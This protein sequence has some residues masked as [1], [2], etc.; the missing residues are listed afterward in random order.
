MPTKGFFSQGVVVF[1]SKPLEIAEIGDLLGGPAKVKTISEGMSA[2]SGPALIV[3]FDPEKGG[4]AVVDLTNGLWPDAMGDPKEDPK[5][6]AAWSMGQFG[7][8]AYPGGLSRATDYAWNWERASDHL[9]LQQSYVRIRI[10]YVFGADEDTPVLPKDYDPR[11]ELDYLTGLVQGLL[12]HP[13]AI[14]YFNPNGEVLMTAEQLD[15]SLQ[16]HSENELPP[17]ETWSNIRLYNVDETWTL[18]DCVGNEQLDQPDHEA[19]FPRRD[20]S[21]DDV[22]AFLR[23]ATMHMLS[24]DDEIVDGDTSNGPGDIAWE[25]YHA[26]D[27]LSDPPRRVIRWLPTGLDELPEMLLDG[28]KK[29]Q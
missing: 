9:A 23:N 29:T 25:G 22:A 8:F 5:T 24:H 15:A 11:A 3:E 14:C 28:I 4:V 10:S 2:G 17:L 6:F 18:M 13:G 16:F 12:K 19:G 7:P 26:T 21:P 1:F 20:F 27:P